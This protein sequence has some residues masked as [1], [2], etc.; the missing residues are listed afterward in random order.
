MANKR[1]AAGTI[2]IE[3]LE[4]VVREME[5]R[6]MDVMAGVEAICH[7]GAEVVQGEIAQRALGRLSAATIR[8]T[9][10]RKPAKVT[11]S[12]GVHKK[13]NYIARFMEFGTDA[14]DI[15]PRRATKR[16]K[17]RKALSIPGLGVF[18]RVEH[19]GLKRRPFIRPGYDASVAGAQTAMKNKT[20]QVVRA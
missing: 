14:H 17:G 8:E 5:R 2:K 9:T 16:R 3:G 18:R 11:V 6:R 20:K 13:L 1:W 12:V 10:Q 15:Q 4:N 19:P 7:A